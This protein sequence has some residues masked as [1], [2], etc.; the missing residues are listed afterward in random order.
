LIAQI[1]ALSFAN[2]GSSDPM[3]L[4]SL[5]LKTRWLLSELLLFPQEKKK[6]AVNTLKYSIENEYLG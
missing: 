2:A 1:S 4:C 6:K 5:Y 3:F